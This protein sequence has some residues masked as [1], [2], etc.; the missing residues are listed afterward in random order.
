MS[1]GASTNGEPGLRAAYHTGRS[2]TE[3][4]RRPACRGK[5]STSHTRTGTQLVAL[6][7]GSKQPRNSTLG[8]ADRPG[9]SFQPPVPVLSAAGHRR[10][11]RGSIT[12]TSGRHRASPR[13]ELTITPQGHLHI[14]G[15][16]CSL[17]SM[18]TSRGAEPD[19]IKPRAGKPHARG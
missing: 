15:E 11:P 6:V 1:W 3:S 14:A 18:G 7:K 5:S 19:V 16:P 9:C 10:A 2:S 13:P 17:L 4:T 12:Q 8:H